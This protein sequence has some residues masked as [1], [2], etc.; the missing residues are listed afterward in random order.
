[1]H[2]ERTFRKHPARVCIEL[3][4]CIAYNSFRI[5]GMGHGKLCTRCKEETEWQHHTHMKAVSKVH[6]KMPANIIR[7][8][9]YIVESAQR[10]EIGCYQ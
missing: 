8:M 7:K 1:M 9:S 6:S 5:D 4:Q 10:P 2:F 3:E